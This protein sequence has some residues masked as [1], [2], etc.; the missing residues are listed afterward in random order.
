MTGRYRDNT[1]LVRALVRDAEVHR[2]VYTSPEVFALEMERLF[3]RTW[4]YVG[5]GSQVPNIGDFFTTTIG[6]QPVVMIR[7]EDGAVH[8]LYN[9]CPH[10]GTRVANEMCGNTG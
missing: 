1:D 5:H 3:A 7:H 6:S 9:R 4:I 10:K 8:V 2:D